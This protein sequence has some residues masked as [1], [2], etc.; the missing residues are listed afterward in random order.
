[1]SAAGT[2]K[3]TDKTKPKIIF[4]FNKGK[5]GI[6]VSDQMS[7]CYSWTRKSLIE[8]QNTG[9]FC[10]ICNRVLSQQKISATGISG[11]PDFL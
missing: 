11:K 5:Q 3:K 2:R 6:D 4:E 9:V 8:Y 1:M 10:W 7:R